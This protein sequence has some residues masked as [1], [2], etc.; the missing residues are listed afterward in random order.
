MPCTKAALRQCSGHSSQQRER[1][2]ATGCAHQHNYHCCVWGEETGWVWPCSIRAGLNDV[3]VR[4]NGFQYDDIT[5]EAFSALQTWPA[6]R[7][8]RPRLPHRNPMMPSSKLRTLHD[9][10]LWTLVCRPMW[11]PGLSLCFVLCCFYPVNHFLILRK[12][13]KELLKLS[14]SCLCLWFWDWKNFGFLTYTCL[15]CVSFTDLTVSNLLIK[16]VNIMLDDHIIW[17]WS[18]YGNLLYGAEIKKCL[19]NITHFWT[20]YGLL[21]LWTH[22]CYFQISR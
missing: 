8:L 6:T 19:R 13:I 9:K 3:W 2:G 20:F 5:D 18:A 4:N 10:Q 21:V 16:I 1:T 17:L 22:D 14:A 12:Y 15:M 11:W 7:Q